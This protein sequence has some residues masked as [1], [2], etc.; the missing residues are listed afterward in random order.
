MAGEAAAGTKLA[1]QVD[2]LQSGYGRVTVLRDVSIEVPAGS[3]VALLG[4]NGAGKSTLLRTIA[5]FLPASTG[6]IRM[7]GV[8]VTRAK[9][10]VRFKAGLSHVPEGRGVFR[11]LTV[12]EN[13]LMQS[14]RGHEEEVLERATLAFP[15]LGARLA[16]RAGTLSGGEQQM[17]AICATYVRDS[18]LILVDEA[19]LGL[20]PRV[21]DAIFTFL[22]GVIAEGRSLLI[23]DQ[24]AARALAMAGTAYV[25]SR[26]RIVYGGPAPDLLESDIFDQYLGEDGRHSHR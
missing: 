7:G 26:G 25:L 16:Q 15:S 1:L 5:G 19:S 10:Y 12:R 9:P 13:L 21:V 20:A 8:D 17:L 3:A 22:E 24:F 11:S 23:A 2:G 6:T 18:A 14:R 4:P